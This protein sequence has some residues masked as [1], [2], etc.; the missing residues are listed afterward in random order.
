MLQCMLKKSDTQLQKLVRLTKEHEANAGVLACIAHLMMARTP[1]W[2]IKKQ[3]ERVAFL[4]Q[5]VFCSY[6]HLKNH[7]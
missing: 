6:F 4:W 3:L 1:T 7:L 2:A 5:G